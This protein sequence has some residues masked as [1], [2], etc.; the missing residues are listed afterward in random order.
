MNS[1]KGLVW[2]NAVT[3]LIHHSSN[4][5]WNIGHSILQD[6]RKFRKGTEWIRK[7]SGEVSKKSQNC[8]RTIYIQKWTEISWRKFSQY[9]EV[10]VTQ[11]LSVWKFLGDISWF[12]HIWKAHLTV[13]I[14]DRVSCLAAIFG[15]EERESGGK[16]ALLSNGNVSVLYLN[17]QT[18][19]LIFKSAQDWKFVENVEKPC[20]IPPLG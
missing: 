4:S 3:V 2:S 6:F 8:M 1:P 14:W 12:L 19:S 9:R 11:M 20:Q 18:I 15:G 7:F 16:R 17:T 13:M 5:L 10:F